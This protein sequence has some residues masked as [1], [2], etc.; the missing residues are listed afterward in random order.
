[1]FYQTTFY[2]ITIKVKGTKYLAKLPREKHY[3]IRKKYVKSTQID[4]N[5]L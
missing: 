2:T 5:K 3:G 1:M 4:L